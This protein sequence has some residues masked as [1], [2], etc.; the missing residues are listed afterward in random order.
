M[1]SMGIEFASAYLGNYIKRSICITF[2][3]NE[4]GKLQQFGKSGK[5]EVIFLQRVIL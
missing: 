1:L 5:K 2:L 3:S 4:R